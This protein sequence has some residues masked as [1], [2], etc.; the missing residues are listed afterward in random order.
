MPRGNYDLMVLA[1]AKD[2]VDAATLVV[3]T[4]PK[5]GTT[6][7]AD[8]LL[9]ASLPNPSLPF[10]LRGWNAQPGSTG[11]R[12]F[13][14]W[15]EVLNFTPET[16]GGTMNVDL[17]RMLAKV[18][19][20][21]A[22]TPAGQVARDKLNIT[23]IMLFNTNSEGYLVSRGY[24]QSATSVSQHAPDAIIT[25]ASH[26]YNNMIIYLPVGAGFNVSVD[27]IF[28]FEAVAAAS[29]ANRTGAVS[30]IIEGRYDGSTVPTYYR[31]DMADSDGNYFDIIR[32]HYYDIVITAI[33]GPGHSLAQDAYNAKPF[34][35]TTAINA[36]DE[37]GMNNHTYDGRY[38]ITVDYD[39]YKFDNSGSPAQPLRI[40]TDVPQGWTI[41]VPAEHNWIKVNGALTA[42]YDNSVVPFVSTTI[43]IT[44]DNNSSTVFSRQGSFFIVAGNLRKEII[45]TQ[46]AAAMWAPP[47][48][49][50]I[51]AGG[52]L[53]LRGSVHYAVDPDIKAYADSEFGGLE[54][55]AVRMIQFKFGSVVGLRSE[56]SGPSF[57][58]DDVVWAPAEYNLAGLIANINVQSTQQ[59][60]YDLV[61]DAWNRADG[62]PNVTNVFTPFPA[63][64]PAN[65][66]AGV[67]DPCALA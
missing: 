38:Q 19:I 43:Q 20:R 66:A 45:V 37:R 42:S 6:T 32:N 52:R 56:V 15:G 23:G 3:G 31:I 47:G 5:T 33:D 58:S 35:I 9:R 14:M 53:T 29:A 11:Y 63:N 10:V 46:E 39:N 22:N 41:E 24:N 40:Y 28:L 61:P 8:R 60:R 36:W 34:N 62:I 2:I 18:N 64:T 55:E 59:A 17:I 30:L 67:G 48:I 4:T 54:G 44:C 12:P 16:S 50:G 21:F 57:I 51:T 65:L 25:P 7:S 1:N 49:L 13:P 27:E 26:G